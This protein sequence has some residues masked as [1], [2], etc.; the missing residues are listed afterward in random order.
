MGVAQKTSEVNPNGID[1]LKQMPVAPAM[2]KIRASWRLRLLEKS[3]FF[4]H[5][6]VHA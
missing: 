4:T 6:D 5:L 2:P 3:Q 1:L